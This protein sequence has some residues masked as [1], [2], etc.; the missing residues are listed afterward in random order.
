MM[1]RRYPVSSTGQPVSIEY[2]CDA[3]VEDNSVEFARK[4]QESLNANTGEGFVMQ[5][6]LGREADRGLVLVYQRAALLS[7]E[8]LEGDELP[9]QGPPSFPPG[10][11]H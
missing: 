9:V 5:T 2:R 7:K 10:M 6:M 11:R 4:L 3:I 8:Q 1:S